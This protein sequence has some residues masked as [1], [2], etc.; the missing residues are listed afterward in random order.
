MLSKFALTFAL[1]SV[2]LGGSA[3]AQ[4][5]G[6]AKTGPTVTVVGVATEDV[7][8]DIAIV[9][10]DIL[11]E[12]PTASDAAGEN[13]RRSTA[14]IEGLEGAGIET[15]DIA[16]IGVSL[17][18]VWND[19]RDAKTG[20][21]VKR[22]LSGYQASNALS[23]RLRAIDKAGSIIEQGVQNGAVYQGVAFDLSDREAR[24][25]ALRVKAVANALHRAALYAQGASM[26]LG[27]LQSI[28]ADLAPPFYR[29]GSGAARTLSVASAATSL[30]VEP[31]LITLSQSVSG[32]WALAPQ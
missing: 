9:T 22:T 6:A 19:E 32:T 28:N 10:F 16:T 5:P 25:D 27:A 12:R 2:A 7:R 30:P 24:E 1:A 4:E 3:L 8:P 11:D 15:K 18:P 29:V 17:T 23:V 26:K 31:G 20:Q 14:V 13:A 21:V